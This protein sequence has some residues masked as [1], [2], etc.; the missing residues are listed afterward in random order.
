MKKVNRPG[1][2]G[3]PALDQSGKVVG[4]VVDQRFKSTP[5][6]G[7]IPVKEL[8]GK[9]DA[10]FGDGTDPNKKPA[11]KPSGAAPGSNRTAEGPTAERETGGQI[12]FQPAEATRTTSEVASDRVD[13]TVRP[14]VLKRVI[15]RYTP[16][17]RAAR[18]SGN[19]VVSVVINERGEISQAKAVSGPELLILPALRAARQC[20]FAPAL[21]NGVPVKVRHP[22]EFSFSLY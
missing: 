15:A 11:K 13:P 16:A 6:S 1:Y 8:A 5:A 17:A 7:V 3:L 9:L 22:L 18:V 20:I 4:V 19:V 10:Y 14:T 21:R 12:A 2:V